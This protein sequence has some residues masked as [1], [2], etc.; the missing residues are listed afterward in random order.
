MTQAFEDHNHSQ[1]RKNLLRQMRERAELEGLRLTPMRER[2]LMILLESHQALGAY[3]ILNRLVNEG[4][5]SQPPIVYRAL[6]FLTDAG[7][8]HKVASQNAYIACQFP[9]RDH[10]AGLMICRK[11]KAVGECCLDGEVLQ[12]RDFFVETQTIEAEGLCEGCREESHAAD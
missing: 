1:C 12:A 4:A 11:C 3:D 2:V 8:V 6:A 7:F 10:Q 9:Q 5:P